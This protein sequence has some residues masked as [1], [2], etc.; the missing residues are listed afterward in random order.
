MSYRNTVETKVADFVIGQYVIFPT[1]GNGSWSGTFEGFG[2]RLGQYAPE[3]AVNVHLIDEN[4]MHH[5]LRTS[6]LYA[7]Y[8]TPVEPTEPT[9]PA[10]PEPVRNVY[11]VQLPVTGEVIFKVEAFSEDEALDLA[12]QMD[13]SEGELNVDHDYS[14]ET[15][16]VFLEEA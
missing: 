8:M 4:G 15:H 14:Q 6:R 3:G 11:E 2:E 13:W 12:T 1:T 7:G 10:E 5:T 9:E 16:V